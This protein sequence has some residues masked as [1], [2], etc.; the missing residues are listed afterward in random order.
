M[1][2]VVGEIETAVHRVPMW[3]WIGL[4]GAGA[5]LV[6]ARHNKTAAAITDPNTPYPDVSG[7]QPITGGGT[8]FPSD[9]G[10]NP[11]QTPDPGAL[12]PA[13]YQEKLT[14]IWGGN[15]QQMLASMTNQPNF[16]S[17]QLPGG[18]SFTTGNN[19]ATYGGG[20]GTPLQS[21]GMQNALTNALRE[22]FT[23][24]NNAIAVSG[25]NAI[26]L[27]RAYGQNYADAITAWGNAGR[28]GDAPVPAITAPIEGGLFGN[29]PA[30]DPNALD[31][32]P[33][34]PATVAPPAV[35]CNSGNYSCI[36]G[37]CASGDATCA[38]RVA[39]WWRGDPI[40]NW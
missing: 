29:T 3:G 19:E 15:L 40:S 36:R 7:G 13:T 23:G 31:Q 30:H 12:V 14:D 28:Q 22:W 2:A 1:S 16:V 8:P 37:N 34:V 5:L 39:S 33:Q 24:N 4:A 11:G 21:V 10:T 27:I 35:S 6:F 9:P 20:N 38:H 26:D 32:T 25:R 18:A 17:V